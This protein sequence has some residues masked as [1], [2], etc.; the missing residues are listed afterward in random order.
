MA[1][2]QQVLRPEPEALR[3]S[4]RR[5]RLALDVLN[6]QAERAETAQREGA[7][8]GAA[9]DEIESAHPELASAGLTRAPGSVVLLMV[10]LSSFVFD[11]TLFNS[12][13]EF[14][15][16]RA[17]PDSP[18][19]VEV[20]RYALP[21]ALLTV[22]LAVALYL[23]FAREEGEET[24]SVGAAYCGWLLVGALLVLVMPA[25][26]VATHLAMRPPQPDAVQ[27]ASFNW[28]LASFVILSLAAHS[29]VLFS[30]RQGHDSKLWLAFTGRRLWLNRV[31][32]RRDRES[33]R[34]SLRVQSAY[35]R[36]LSLRDAH[37]ADYP[38]HT[39]SS[40]PF[41]KSAREVLKALAG[42]EVVIVRDA[43]PPVDA[44]PNPT[45]TPAVEG[46][47]QPARAAGLNEPEPPEADTAWDDAARD[48]P[49]VR[50]ADTEVKP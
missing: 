43:V 4:R 13:A 40:G 38:G 9:L 21:V 5:T 24:G 47:A 49:A 31:V 20:A 44:P 17:F 37:N 1:S 33:R 16:R 46:D 8:A 11:V 25:S 19:L 26:V 10:T 29:V 48:V 50:D 22:E 12:A 28:Q 7:K 30:G 15:A 23:H 6:V 3:R 18:V 34:A 35:A 39:V 45:A 36:Y 2:P 27:E 42:Y 41:T 32:R 14:Y